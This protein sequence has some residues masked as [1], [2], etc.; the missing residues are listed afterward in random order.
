MHMSKIAIAASVFCAAVPSAH[1][2]APQYTF[3]DLGVMSAGDSS[4]ATAIS[5]NGQTIVGRNLGSTSF[6]P[7]MWSSGGAIIGMSSPYVYSNALAVNDSG[8]S[9]GVGQNN[10]RYGQTPMTWSSSGVGTALALPSDYLTGQANGINNNGIIV[11]SVGSSSSQRAAMWN[12]G[13]P[14][15]ISATAADG[16]FMTVAKGIN[17]SGLIVGQGVN[18]NN[19]A[20]S[21]GL[22]YDTVSGKMTELAPLSG[23]NGTAPYA[24][25]SSG[26]IA[27]CSNVNGGGCTPVVWSSNGTLTQMALPALASSGYGVAINASGQVL[28]SGGGAYSVPFLFDGTATYSIASLVPASVIAEGWDF[29]NNTATSATGISDQGVIVGTANSPGGTAHAYELIPTAAVPEPGTLAMM[30]AG[31]L[32]ISGLSRRRMKRDR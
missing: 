13:V 11:G 17:A 23:M 32:M 1:A 18:P 25:N 15:I 3:V 29:S 26:A 6:T 24:I 30:V 7:V 28:G 27:G 5:A 4:Q 19:A 9:V 10:L 8:V 2:D 31:C 21:V 20:L 14:S 16:S 12:N 22:V